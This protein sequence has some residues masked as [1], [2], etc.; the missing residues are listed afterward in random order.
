MCVSE[1]TSH[2]SVLEGNIIL[3][4]FLRELENNV[5]IW[6]L[7]RTDVPLEI[8]NLCFQT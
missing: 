8:H 3:I 1:S 2:R 4:L 7:L 5:A 6:I